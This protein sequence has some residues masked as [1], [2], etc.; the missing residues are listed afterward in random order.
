[1]SEKA[2]RSAAGHGEP[3]SIRAG[4]WAVPVSRPEK[5][6]F[7]T[8]GITKLDLAE[9]YARVAPLMLPLVRGRPVA[10]ERFP[11]GLGGPRFY[12]KNVRSV[13]DWV[14]TETVGKKGGELT[15]VVCDN[16]ATLVWMADQACITPH[17]WLSRVDRPKYPDQL[18]FDLDPPEGKFGEA[19]RLAL[20]LRELLDDLG[21]P[22]FAKTTGGKGLHVMV[23]LD[24]RA[25]YGRVREFAVRVGELLVRRDP[26]RLTMEFR[27]ANREGRLFVDLGRNAYSQHAVAPYAVRARDGAPVATPLHWTEVEDKRLRP[28]RFTI[29]AVAERVKRGENPW[30]TPR[31]RSLTRPARVLEQMHAE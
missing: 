1:M 2:V 16:A 26:K 5:V 9:H 11:D 15:Q 25:D 19:R 29:R 27:K 30:G 21:L 6:L 8:D 4:R 17:L 22:S 10:M 20:V 28:E 14:R 12:H 31:A 18:M 7:P 3:A 24:R 13:P 23:P